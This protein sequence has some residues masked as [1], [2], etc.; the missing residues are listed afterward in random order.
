[1][2]RLQV[3]PRSNGL[4]RASLRHPN[5]LAAPALDA[6]RMS[7]VTAVGPEITLKSA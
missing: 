4:V 5:G 3:S 6:G 1:M 2:K 7:C